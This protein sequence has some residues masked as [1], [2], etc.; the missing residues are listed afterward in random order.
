M[1]TYTDAATI[2]RIKHKEAMQITAV[3]NA[4]FAAA[5]REVRPEDWAK[6]TDCARWDVRGLAAHVI[7]SA[8]GQASPREFVR[9]VRTGKPIVAEIGAEYWW[10]GMNELHVRERETASVE[11]L[12]AEWDANSRRALR[13]R[14]RLPRPVAWL[15]LIDLPAPV[16]R[17]PVSYLFDMGFTRDVWMHRVDLTHAA[18]TT[19]DATP[20]HDGR[21][22]ADLVAEW[23]ATHGEPFA[24]TLTGP[25][26]GDYASGQ[27]G[28]H[29]EI[30]AL[31]FARTLSGRVSG[32]GVLRHPLPL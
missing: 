7:G 9:Q 6:P 2:D 3:E 5:L 12:K 15:P 17:K 25:A 30:D 22:V 31:E 26:G 18:G 1:I 4:K 24:L 19:F 20:E 8:A 16:G 29:V 13:A 23:A 27:N 32:E 11:D 14:R 21:I 28:E 10:D